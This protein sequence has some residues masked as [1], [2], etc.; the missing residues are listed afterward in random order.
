ME[1][2][3]TQATHD[4]VVVWDNEDTDAFMGMDGHGHTVE[5]AQAH[6]DHAMAVEW[7][8]TDHRYVVESVMQLSSEIDPS[9]GEQSGPITL[10]YGGYEPV[11]SSRQQSRAP[12]ENM[13]PPDQ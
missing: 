5:C 7:C 11:D 12:E 10:A 1:T 13:S 6:V 8:I 4:H 2:Q 9:T 3:G